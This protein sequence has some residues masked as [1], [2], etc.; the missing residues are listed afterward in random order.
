MRIELGVPALA[1]LALAPAARLPADVP[2]TVVVLQVPG[3]GLPGQVPEAMPERFVLLEDGS[4][5]VGGTGTIATARLEKG[6]VRDIEKSLDRI[7]KIPGLGSVVTFGPGDQK[8]RLIVR[9][10]RALDITAS[11]DTASA[12]PGL[13]PLASLM[14]TLARFDTPSLHPYRPASFALSAREGVLPG[15]CRPWTFPGSL[16]QALAAPQSVAASA[17]ER[18]PT[19]G[20]PASVCAGDKRYVVTLRPLLPGE[21]P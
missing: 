4:V 7:R 9:K 18:W 2:S 8:R 14:D 13:R 17:A 10:G 1:F 21:K 15:G 5:Y 11:G 20:Q 16:P 6:E 19:G 12:P 3:G